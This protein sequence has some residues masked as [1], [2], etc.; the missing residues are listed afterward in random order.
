MIGDGILPDEPMTRSSDL[1]IVA[2]ALPLPIR[3]EFSYRVPP[4]MAAA[5]GSVAAG[6]A[7][8]GSQG[9]AIHS[10]YEFNAVMPPASRDA[11]SAAGGASTPLS[12]GP[13]KVTNYEAGVK[14]EL[15]D[16]RL[17]L[18]LAAFYI[19]WKNVQLNQLSPFGTSFYTNAG[20]AVSKGVEATADWRP[21]SCGK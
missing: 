13:D 6:L 19:D 18:D 1:P 11:E 16:R 8:I 4:G 7:S 12:Y 21:T 15:F 14:T 20:K 9:V 3:Q 2:V 17:A 5:A 10:A